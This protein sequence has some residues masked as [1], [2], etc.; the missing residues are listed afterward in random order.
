MEVI[1]K[2]HQHQD[3]FCFRAH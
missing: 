1:M 3:L 2:K